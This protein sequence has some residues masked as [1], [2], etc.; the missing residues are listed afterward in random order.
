ML[1]YDCMLSALHETRPCNPPLVNSVSM[2]GMVAQELAVLLVRQSRL[3]SL[4]LSVTC[5]GMQPLGGF[6]SPVLGVRVFKVRAALCCAAL[7]CA[8]LR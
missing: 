5:R 6:L 3:V 1:P 2:G 4:A 7:C 8:V